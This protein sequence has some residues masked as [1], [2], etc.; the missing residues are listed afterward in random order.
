MVLIVTF[1]AQFASKTGANIKIFTISLTTE[2]SGA[3][4]EGWGTGKQKR[5]TGKYKM[6]NQLF[7]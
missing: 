2:R 4:G 6:I 7:Q 3:E 5:S 1:G